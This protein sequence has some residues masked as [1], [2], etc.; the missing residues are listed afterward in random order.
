[1]YHEKVVAKVPGAILPPPMREKQGYIDDLSS[2]Q[3]F[4]LEELLE[5]QNKLLRNEKFVAKLPDKGARIINFRDKIQRELK[6]KN[7]IERAGDLF[8][9]LNIASEGKAKMN[10]LEWTGKYTEDRGTIKV[11]QL[12]SDDEDDPL[13]ILAQPT[14]SGT[15]KKK[16]VHLP[17]EES[18][19][20]PE[21]FK[22][23]E[24]F[25]DSVSLEHVKYILGVV[26]RP[27]VK[28]EKEKHESFKPYKTTRSNVHDPS[29]ELKRR[30][31][32]HWEVTAATPP[33]SI[34]GTVKEVNIMES[35]NLQ[36]K[37][38][39]KFQEIQTQN[40]IMKL[41]EQFTSQIGDS[42]PRMV[43]NHRSTIS[44]GSSSDSEG[45]DEEN[46][47]R[48]DDDDD[49]KAGTVTYMIEN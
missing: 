7:D 46:E 30:K 35:L 5:R 42:A 48:D 16:V 15:H 14:G 13:K 10:E 28:G 27:R 24:T 2:K 47:A 38:A 44:N 29:N 26:E 21:D 17:P 45:N 41:A 33:P 8:S 11:V 49:D 34:H 22:E 39:E 1:M 3:I 36:K 4:E 12:D 40:T 18:L 6:S 25:D 20:T 37:Q 23:I 43:G 32:P 9:R 19:I 31:H